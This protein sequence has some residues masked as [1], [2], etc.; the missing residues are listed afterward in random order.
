MTLCKFARMRGICSLLA[1]SLVAS[2]APAAEFIINYNSVPAEAQSAIQSAADIW[3]DILVSTVPIK[4]LVNWVPMGGAA[5]GITFPNGR[6]DFPDAPLPDTWYATSLANSITGEELN[7]GENDFEIWLNNMT[8]WYY[9][10]D[11]LPGNAQHDLVSVALHEFG[12]GLGF[13]GL[14]KK[15]G[16]VGSFGLLEMSDFAPLFTTFP[17]PEL[18][19]L[20]GIFDRYLSHSQDGPLTQMSNPSDELGTAQTSAQIYFNGPFAMAANNG[21]APRIY[22]PS[23]FAL[24]SSCVHLNENTYPSG[25]PNELMT[26]FSAAG[27]ANHWPG[28]LCLAMLRDIGW[29]LAPDVGIDEHTDNGTFT[30]Y[31]NPTNDLLSFQLA[32]A[33]S[34]TLSIIDA[35]GRTLRSL[36]FTSTIDVRDLSPGAYVLRMDGTS[37]NVPFIKN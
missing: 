2:S 23:T 20:P 36:S 17:W 27:D 9:G 7:P 18:D 13:V 14:S 24:G 12:H 16:S 29:T 31:P 11:G 37:L 5:L 22:A 15:E 25:N 28:P 1:L 4:V 10:T 32:M 33:P 6:R 8:D 26:P 30:V 3:G 21:N 35:Q 19:T 34:R